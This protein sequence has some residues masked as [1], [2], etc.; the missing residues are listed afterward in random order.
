MVVS[1][2]VLLLKRVIFRPVKSLL[3]YFRSILSSVAPISTIIISLEGNRLHN[4][5]NFVVGVF[6]FAHHVKVEIDFGV[7]AAR[8]GFTL[9]QA[10]FHQWKFQQLTVLKAR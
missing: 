10:N 3:H 8:V 6:H 5:L 1:V 2:V 7:C 4:G 9:H